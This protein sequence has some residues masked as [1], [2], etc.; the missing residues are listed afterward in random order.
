MA[1]MGHYHRV[2]RSQVWEVQW[3]LY[4][5]LVGWVFGFHIGDTQ[6]AE[7]SLPTKAMSSDVYMHEHLS[8]IQA[9]KLSFK[10]DLVAKYKEQLILPDG[11]RIKN[12]LPRH[13][14]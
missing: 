2:G 6:Q 1:H 14:N 7:K 5:F 9:S 8:T 10:H 12:L 11:G 13:T 4:R 3:L